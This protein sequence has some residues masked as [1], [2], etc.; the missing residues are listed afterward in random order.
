MIDRI[1]MIS[2]LLDPIFVAPLWTFRF[3]QPD[4]ETKES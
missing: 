3:A 2:T 1:M 4:T